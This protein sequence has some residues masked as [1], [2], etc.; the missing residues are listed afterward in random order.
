MTDDKRDQAIKA[1]ED[2]LRAELAYNGDHDI[3]AGENAII[4]RLLER[5]SEVADAYVEIF[6]RLGERHYGVPKLLGVVVTTAALWSPRQV[7]Q[8]CAARDR[9]LKVNELIATR[10]AELASLLAERSELHD[11]SGFSGNTHYHICR[12]IEDAASDNYLYKSWVKQKMASLRGE[13]D[14]KY[15]PR[16][17]EVVA[18]LGRDAEHVELEATDPITAAATKGNRRSRADFFKALYEAIDENSDGRFGTLPPGL[19]LT[20]NVIASLANCALDLPP[21]QLVDGAYVKRLRQRARGRRSTK[22]GAATRTAA[23]PMSTPE[24]YNAQRSSGPR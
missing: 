11:H 1:C 17:H 15:W 8:T 5:R 23:A 19:R 7:A 4:E 14:L 24:G 20:D 13:F 2:A 18:A 21:D 9:L 16:I 10:A 3:L 6:D 12:V 22:R